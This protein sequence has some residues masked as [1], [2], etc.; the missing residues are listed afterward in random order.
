MDTC[1]ICK[2]PKDDLGLCH[3]HCPVMIAEDDQ[4][5]AEAYEIMDQPD[6]MDPGLTERIHEVTREVLAFLRFKRD[7]GR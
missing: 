5:R 3:P 2:E 1:P 6:D 7:L 4:A